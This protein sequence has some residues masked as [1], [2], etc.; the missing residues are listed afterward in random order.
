[1]DIR[2]L[3]VPYSLSIMTRVQV[4]EVQVQNKKSSPASNTDYNVY[5]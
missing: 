3:A 2:A 5:D 4:G 1:M